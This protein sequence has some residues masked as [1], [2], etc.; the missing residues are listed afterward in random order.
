MLGRSLNLRAAAVCCALFVPLLAAAEAKKDEPLSADAQKHLVATVEKAMKGYNE[1]DHKAFYADWAKSMAPSTT[2][3]NFKKFYVEMN[4]K[5]FHGK[6]LEMS[7][8]DKDERVVLK[9]DYPVL[10]FAA[11]FEKNEKT[12][13]NAAFAREGDTFKLVQ[14]NLE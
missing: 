7:R 1:Q 2:E 3:E 8:D 10:I 9:G 11:K 4:M 13:I 5:K 14:L 6:M 12:K